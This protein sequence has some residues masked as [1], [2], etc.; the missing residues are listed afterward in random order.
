MGFSLSRVIFH[1]FG[2][3]LMQLMLGCVELLV[4]TNLNKRQ[5]HDCPR[6]RD[7]PRSGYP[8]VAS[9]GKDPPRNL[10]A[11]SR[12]FRTA[13]A[14][15][16]DFVPAPSESTYLHF[17]SLKH[18]IF[19]NKEDMG[20]KTSGNKA[21]YFDKLKDLLDSY[22]SIFIVGVDNVSSQQVRRVAS[23]HDTI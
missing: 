8:P 17:K 23:K 20:G 3:P 9:L 2:G 13:S 14:A 12:I 15:S 1:D 19:E 6:L 16:L 7:A 21:A 11:P 10:G 22:K 5:S 18:P 4:A